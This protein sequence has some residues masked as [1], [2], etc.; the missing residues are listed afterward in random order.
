[1]GKHEYTLLAKGLLTRPLQERSLTMHHGI[2][3]SGLMT[4]IGQ[5]HCS[6]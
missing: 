2:R 3:T 1:M 5:I 6:D 4:F